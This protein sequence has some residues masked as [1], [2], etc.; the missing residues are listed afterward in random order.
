M[1][2]VRRMKFRQ[3]I[4]WLLVTAYLAGTCAIM[5]YIFEISDQYNTFAVDHVERYHN[6]EAVLKKQAKAREDD[7]AGSLD[8][9]HSSS[10]FSFLWH[11]TDIPLAVWMLLLLLPYLQVFAM[12]LAC[13]KAEPRLSMAYIWP[14][15]VF[16][17]LRQWYRQCRGY[18]TTSK[19]FNS[20][21]PNGHP[22]INT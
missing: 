16:L 18:G 11:I 19:A 1:G 3:R 5:Y 2:L 22:L 17:R 21:I 9:A 15:Y 4:A 14:V 7:I 8:D 12:L 6:V 10:L 20:P 13:T